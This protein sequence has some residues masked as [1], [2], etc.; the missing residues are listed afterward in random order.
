[1]AIDL[2]EIYELSEG[3][4]F[5]VKKAAGRDGDGQLPDSFWAS[6]SAMANTEGGV[7]L[8]GVE[9]TA[10][11][12][13]NVVG[14][15]NPQKIIQ[16]LWNLANNSQK[17]SAN[18]LHSDDAQV[19]DVEGKRVV[20]VRVPRAVRPQRPVYVGTNP[21]KGTYQRRGDG[22]FLCSEESV[23]RMLADQVEEARDAKLL[24]H[25]D[26]DDLNLPT[27]QAYRNAFK[28]V[29]PDHPWV[30][31]D[32]KEFLCNIGGWTKNRETGREGLTVAGILMFGK[33]RSI[34][35][36]LPNYV[37]DYQERPTDPNDARRWM[38]RV[39]TDGTWSGN[40]YDFFRTVIQRLTRDLKVPFL[41]KGVT[42]VDDTPVH[43]ALREALV[44]EIIHADF[45]GRVS[46]LVVKRA[47]MFGFRNPG[48]MRM[49]IEQAIRGGV[50][51]CRN[52]NLQKM[53]QLVGLAE[54]AGSGLN[55]VFRNWKGQ[56]WRTP[57]LYENPELDATVLRLHM[58]SLLPKETLEELDARFGPRFRGLSETER[59]ALATAS[60]E[61]RVTH[62]RLRQMSTDHPRDL[63]A[64][65]G[66]LVDD[67]FLVSEGVGRGTVYHLPNQPPTEEQE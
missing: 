8:L 4:E 10:D 62:A 64:T 38:D 47:D 34:L 24:D 59:L 22:D 51:D 9:E 3:L 7:I 37:V 43:E 58:A 66:R 23:K 20:R 35:D 18:I 52:R 56:H 44:N 25:Y 11:H 49:P 15:A 5:E 50:S 55:K 16:D 61:G 12:K 21:F 57:Q 13:F 40:L 29:K 42:R 6:Y 33:L 48:V 63:S 26:F 30:D 1:M 32:D 60:I 14:I 65:L 46:L 17:I 45:T 2:P 39:T 53:F 31:L 28:S 27:L 19:L 41:L 67:G 36:V 54:Q